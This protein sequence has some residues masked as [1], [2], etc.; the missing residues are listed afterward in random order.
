MRQF[1]WDARRRVRSRGRSPRGSQERGRRVRNRVQ[2]VRTREVV[3]YV[4][5]SDTS[6]LA[7]SK[8]A[9]KELAEDSGLGASEGCPLILGRI[10]WLGLDGLSQVQLVNQGA[11]LPGAGQTKFWV[12]PDGY[13]WQFRSK[14]V[15]AME[16]RRCS[17]IGAASKAKEQAAFLNG[18]S[19]A[20]LQQRGLL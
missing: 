11:V 8:M 9:G 12:S 7:P 14:Y 17:F 20:Q 6:R 13:F 1:G 19:S 2:E 3:S 5:E 16:G 10:G 15:G 4:E 18:L